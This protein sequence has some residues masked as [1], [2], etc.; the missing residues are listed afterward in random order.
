[1]RTVAC[2]MHAQVVQPACAPAAAEWCL[3]C[4]SMLG[5]S[6]RR[7]VEQDDRIGCENWLRRFCCNAPVTPS[8]A[9]HLPHP[10]QDA[11]AQNL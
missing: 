4:R 6:E 7:P 10:K 9:K 5:S 1:M 8:A 11:H 2:C 3:W